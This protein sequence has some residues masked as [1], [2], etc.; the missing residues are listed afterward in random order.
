MSY[1]VVDDLHKH[2]RDESGLSGLFGGG[3]EP[4]KAVNGVDLTVKRGEAVGLVGES[5]CGKSTLARTL[6]GLEDPTEGNIEIAGQPVSNQ[7]ADELK[8]MRR[9]VQMVF[10]DPGSSL[11]PRKL[12]RSIVGEALIVHD[13]IRGTELDAAV[14]DLL[15]QVGLKEEHLY[16]YPTEL[17]GGQ[18]QRVAIARALALDPE[19]IIFDEPTSALDMSVQAEILNLIR[20]L[21]NEREFASLIISHD[22][23]VIKHV[24]DRVAVMYLGEIVE[25]GD[26][27]KVLSSPKHP[28]T[29]TLYSSIPEPTTDSVFDPDELHGELPDPTDLP[30]GCAFHTRCPKLIKPDGVEISQEAWLAVHSLKRRVESRDIETENRSEAE[31]RVSLLPDVDLGT[32]ERRVKRAVTAIID[33]D[34]DTAEE[35]LSQYETVCE[36]TDPT[37]YR[38]EESNVTAACHRHETK[39]DAIPV[40]GQ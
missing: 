40:D 2:Y 29:E 36:T 25:R 8:E 10:Q 23:S 35:V 26:A 14:L 21:K 19:M 1:I 9:N 33:G 16:R 12:I 24:C 4:V 17:S 31:L 37:T 38:F 22:L 5:G 3:G 11:N 39:S 6:I 30:S 32:A 15:E 28:Y 13:G 34:W 20:R 27:A 7:S 18:R